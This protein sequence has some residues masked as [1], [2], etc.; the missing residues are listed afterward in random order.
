MSGE[1]TRRSLL[2]GFL[3]GA[4]VLGG[5]VGS[6]F[7]YFALS[8]TP[9]TP[10]QLRVEAAPNAEDPLPLDVQRTHSDLRTLSAM[11]DAAWNLGRA[12]VP[13]SAREAQLIEAYLV[14]ESVR[15]GRDDPSDVV[16]WRGETFRVL[17][18]PR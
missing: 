11:L 17:T 10:P 4:L 5:L 7:A 14:A 3:S 9:S 2:L 6:V 13:I 18:P 16:L 12:E 1:D 8:E 15:Q